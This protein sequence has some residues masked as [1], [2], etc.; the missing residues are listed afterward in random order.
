MIGPF[1]NDEFGDTYIALYTLTGEG[2]SLAEVVRKI[3]LLE[4]KLVAAAR[5]WLAQ[6]G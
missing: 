4:E 1:F 6:G 5:E 2:F 3:Q